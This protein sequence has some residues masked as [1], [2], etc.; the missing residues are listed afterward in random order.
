LQGVFQTLTTTL[1]SLQR[2]RQQQSTDSG[3]A[4]TEPAATDT[5][6]VTEGS[7]LPADT[8][9]A[10][11]D[12][13]PVESGQTVSASGSNAV[14]SGQTVQTVVVSDSNSDW[15]ATDP[16]K[17]VKVVLG[18]VT[19]AVA[20]VTLAVASVPG[21]IASL[22]TSSTPVT[23]VITAVQTML[24]LVTNAVVP[25]LQVPSD[26]AS[27]L[28]V[29]AMDTAP[30]VGGG[31]ARAIRANAP[32]PTAGASQR[33]GVAPI[34]LA[35]GVPL[36]DSIAGPTVLGDIATTAFS[37]ELP[38]SGIASP[39]QSVID[40]TGMGA[41]LEH[42]VGALLVPASLSALAAVALPG[43]G[44]LL[45]ICAA[46]ARLGYRQ[47]KALMEVR[48]TGIARF[49]GSGPLGVVRTGSLI[50]LR[51][52]ASRVVRPRA[53]LATCPP[54]EQAAA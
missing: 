12:S 52:R 42:T 54:L 10:A 36:P 29:P 5:K 32:V 18:P 41:F 49:A 35:G 23:D 27:L 33:L 16:L 50:A 47:A 2:Q 22:P 17:P 25:L 21:V 6:G 31:A 15:R 13:N 9:P 30:T 43:V 53:S 44:G 28:G 26:L 24:T 20:T 45:I 4:Q 48:S 39:A 7:P 8:S 14:E 19:N 34:F 11:S 40:K 37:H 3:P 51:P 38:V 1:R 46:G